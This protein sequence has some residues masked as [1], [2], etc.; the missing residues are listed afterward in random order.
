[1]TDKNGNP[2]TVGARVRF[3]SKA[4]SDFREGWVRAVRNDGVLAR[5]DDGKKHDEYGE[6]FSVAAWVTS[7]EIEVLP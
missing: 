3:P 1:M 7:R 6:T 2:V 4:N 5:V